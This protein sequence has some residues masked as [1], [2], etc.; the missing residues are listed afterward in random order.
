[1]PHDENDEPGPY[2]AGAWAE[3]RRKERYPRR[4]WPPWKGRKGK[5]L[6]L[7]GKDGREVWPGRGMQ[8]IT[9][10]YGVEPV[11]G[12]EVL[13]RG[14]RCPRVGRIVGAC[15]GNL[16]VRFTV[17]GKEQTWMLHPVHKLEYR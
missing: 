10:Y 17:C 2:G 12:R 15:R 11:I 5:L 9:D 6:P 14:G 16:L 1:M 8:Q 7:G 13:Y 4:G 3:L